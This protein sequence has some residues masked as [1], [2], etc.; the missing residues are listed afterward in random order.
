MA[1]KGVFATKRFLVGDFLMEYAGER[2]SYD[3]AVKRESDY[4][5]NGIGCFIY[6][7]LKGPTGEFCLDATSSRQSGKY[8]NDTM[9]R[10]ANAHTKKITIGSVAY[11][12]LFAKTI[13]EPGDEIRYDYGDGDT[14][15]SWRSKEENLMPMKKSSLESFL[16]E[17][18]P[19]EKSSKDEWNCNQIEDSDD[20]S[21]HCDDKSGHCDEIQQ[22]INEIIDDIENGS[23]RSS[24]KNKNVRYEGM[25]SDHGLETF[26]DPEILHRE[27]NQ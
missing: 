25:D 11:I 18:H 19:K 4:E 21:G 16:V 3:E 7:S 15:C 22:I 8:V 20:K 14:A 5:Y 9:H 6:F 1:G 13:I 26:S 17:N 12:C 2:I 27:S 23:R 24:T 10:F